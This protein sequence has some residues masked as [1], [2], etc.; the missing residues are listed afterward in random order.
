MLRNLHFILVLILTGSITTSCADQLGL[1][2]FDDSGSGKNAV[3]LSVLPEKPEVYVENT[4]ST[5]LLKDSGKSASWLGFEEPIVYEWSYDVYS[6]YH[7]S[8]VEFAYLDRDEYLD[9][10]LSYE[11]I[12]NGSSY[13][14]NPGGY[15]NSIPVNDK[16]GIKIFLNDDGQGLT[17][18][19]T[20]NIASS[21]Y[22][23]DIGDLNLDGFPDL[24]YYGFWANGIKI[25]WGLSDSP[26]T[27][28]TS[29]PTSYN[30]GTHGADAFI[31]DYN[32]DGL[33]DLVSPANGSLS[34]FS[35][36]F[37]EGTGGKTLNKV[38]SVVSTLSNITECGFAYFHNFHVV[39][40]GYDGKPEY[41]A[42]EGRGSKIDNSLLYNTCWLI[43][44]GQ[45]TLPV[46]DKI[47][48]VEENWASVSVPTG[49]NSS[50]I[51]FFKTTDDRTIMRQTYGDD[52]NL[53]GV[54]QNSYGVGNAKEM[55]K[56]ELPDIVYAGDFRE[57]GHY[58]HIDL[59]S[60]GKLDLIAP[61][62]IDPQ[63]RGKN[64]NISY[65][66]GDSGNTFD[67]ELKYIIKD[68]PPVS[69]M[70][71]ADLNRDG[72]PD[73]VMIEK[74]YEAGSRFYVVGHKM[75]V[76]MSKASK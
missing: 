51:A 55:V 13:L 18:Q 1:G 36:H 70:N 32:G 58:K 22:L 67:S 28:D 72:F 43:N 53:L 66:L 9:V 68:V 20:I 61:I 35:I 30:T 50:S 10:L 24:I 69:G 7:F 76:F 11:L 38:L 25:M 39:D 74:I 48:N 40:L 47:L 65:L 19:Q 31:T 8:K 4:S 73:L 26:P 45:S 17:H 14:I 49:L 16:S 54:T 64:H 63:D 2:L 41:F 42:D 56:L 52:K 12:S 5:R 57:D 44:T 6:P 3:S 75:R 62:P 37:F 71:H 15:K 60:D 21:E 34:P 23:S 33:P 27:F 46:G 29:N 59:N